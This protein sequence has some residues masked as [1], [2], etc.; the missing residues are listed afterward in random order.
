MAKNIDVSLKTVEAT[1][2]VRTS[3][4]AEPVKLTWTIDYTS[5]PMAELLDKAFRT[6]AITLQNRYRKNPFE[7]TTFDAHRDIGTQKPVDQRTKVL[8]AMKGLTREQM[9][10]L[11]DAFEE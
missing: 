3:E 7:Q 5:T 1:V 10:E 6:D 2:K 11:V 4:S 9:Q 8:N